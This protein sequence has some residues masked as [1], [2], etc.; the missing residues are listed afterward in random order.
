M[1]LCIS[2]TGSNISLLAELWRVWLDDG[3]GSLPCNRWVASSFPTPFI[4][5]VASL[6]KTLH[7]SCLPVTV[8]GSGGTGAWQPQ[9]AVATIHCECVC[10]R[11]NVVWRALESSWLDKGLIQVCRAR[12]TSKSYRDSGPLGLHFETTGLQSSFTLSGG[13]DFWMK[14]KIY[15][16]MR[17]GVWTTQ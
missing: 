16:H 13:F 6:G 9:E 11:V 12:D 17:R 4:S 3:N 5:F 7:S 8:K 10:E 1:S 14:W 2:T 15:F